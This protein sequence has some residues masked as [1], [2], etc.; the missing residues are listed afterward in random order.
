M[1]KLS[2]IPIRVPWPVEKGSPNLRASTN[3]SGHGIVDLIAFFGPHSG[4]YK[5]VALHVDSLL[6]FR[7][8]P[9]F[10][11][12]QPLD[13]E[14]F[15]LEVEPSDDLFE[16]D[17]EKWLDDACELWR[18]TGYAPMPGVYT[19]RGASSWAEEL[20]AP[21]GTIHYVV[22]GE[23]CYSEFLVFDGDIEIK[24]GEKVEW[25]IQGPYEVP[26]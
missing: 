15:S 20:D 10:A 23:D 13:P 2:L 22:T 7:M 1:S 6:A 11:E 12:G 14:R 9:V 8:L 4:E 3:E 25:V 17:P 26:E 19:V 16:S 5:F 24:I 18:K 21:P